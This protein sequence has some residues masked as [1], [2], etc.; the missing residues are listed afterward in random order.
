MEVLSAVG[1]RKVPHIRMTGD[2]FNEEATFAPHRQ[3]GWQ[4]WTKDRAAW[5]EGLQSLLELIWAQW[6]KVLEYIES[7]C[8]ATAYFEE[9]PLIHFVVVWEW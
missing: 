9:D 2:R 7:V 1:M 6:E 5:W 4:L 8:P 3:M